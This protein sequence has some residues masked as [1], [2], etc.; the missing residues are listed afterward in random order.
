M[1]L[2]SLR[3]AKVGVSYVALV[4]GEYILHKPHN[5]VPDGHRMFG[6]RS[7]ARSSLKEG[8]G[9]NLFHFQVF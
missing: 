3:C 7:A 1:K 6:E 2:V 9:T 8:K 5:L 4:R